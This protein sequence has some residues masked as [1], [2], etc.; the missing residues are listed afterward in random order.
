[1]SKVK[2]YTLIIMMLLLTILLLTNS[3][4]AEEISINSITSGINTG[5]QVKIDIKDLE[6]NK[7]LYC[8]QH[9]KNLKVLSKTTYTITNYFE[10]NGN[11]L[12]D[13]HGNCFNSN[14]INGEIAYILSQGDG[15]GVL[16][17]TKYNSAGVAI[18]F[19]PVYS[20]GQKALYKKFN[21]WVHNI[22]ADTANAYAYS[23]NNETDDPDN[24]ILSDA[25]NY[26]SSIASIQ[27]VSNSDSTNKEN[28]T[29]ELYNDIYGTP[30]Y[31]V[32]PFNWT[33]SGT[34]KEMKVYDQNQNEIS[35][36][37]IASYSGNEGNWGVGAVQSGKDFYII[38]KANTGITKISKMWAKQESSKQIK[39]AKI[40]LLLTSDQQNLLAV[41]T[42]TQDSTNSD[43][44]TYEYDKP[45]RG[46]F[47]LTKVDKNDHEIKLAGVQFKIKNEETGF[48]IK[49]SEST[50]SY[51]A[52]EDATTFETNENGQFTINNLL[53]GTYTAYEISNP[54]YGYEVSE[55]GFTKYVYSNCTDTLTVE[56]ELKYVKIGGYAWKDNPNQ[57]NETQGA[58]DNLYYKYGEKY[59]L[60]NN[61]LVSTD[62]IIQGIIVNL[63]DSKGNIVKTA[64][65][66]STGKYEF[67]DVLI[68][69]LSDYYV[70]FVY[71][72]FSYTPVDSNKELRKLSN[73]SKVL[74]VCEQRTALNNKFATVTGTPNLD[75]TKGQ[76]NGANGKE[77]DLSYNRQKM[78]ENNENSKYLARYNNEIWTYKY[79]GDL[80][81]TNKNNDTYNVSANTL[82]TSYSL[83]DLFNNAMSNKNMDILKNINLGLKEREQSNAIIYNND[84]ET[85]KLTING[86]TNVYK[87]G[88]KALTERPENG[89]NVATN[90]ST[91]KRYIYTSDIK[92]NETHK[93]D[94]RLRV[95]VTYKVTLKNA[96]N[97]LHMDINEL[98]DYYDAKYKT[99][100]ILVG[101]EFDSSAEN[102]G[103]KNPEK[104]VAR[105]T[106]ITN[107]NKYAT[108]E[109][110]GTYI[111]K[112]DRS[113]IVRLA[114]NESKDIFMQYE[115][116]DNEVL[117]ILNG[118]RT[119]NNVAEIYSYTTY[120]KTT[121]GKYNLYAA[122]DNDSAAGNTKPGEKATYEN[123]TNVAP[124]LALKSEGE[125]SLGG[126][127]FEDKTSG[128][129][130]IGQIREGD[131]EY[132]DG[133][134]GIAGV[135]VIMKE[136]KDD[137]LKHVI[138]TG[139]NGDY[140][141][142]GFVPGDYT[143]TYEWGN[144]KYTVQDYK[145]TIYK[146]DGQVNNKEWY[147]KENPR[148]SDA[149]DN[150]EIRKNIDAEIT[151][152]KNSTEMLLDKMEST[153]PTL[154]IGI[155]YNSTQTASQGN[156]YE[157]RINNI[158]FGISE[159]AR[160][161]VTLE[162][163]V[164]YVKL[165][166]PNGQILVEGDPRTENLK[167]VSY[168]SPTKDSKG[169]VQITLDNELIHGSV[170]Q[171]KYEFTLTNNSEL[172][173]I[174][175]KYY[176]YG[177]SYYS[178]LDI[179]KDKKVKV[180]SS[181]IVDYVDNELELSKDINKV[182]LVT[183][184]NLTDNKYI[185]S[186]EQ[187]KGEINKHTTIGMLKE[188]FDNLTLEPGQ[189]TVAKDII[190]MTKLLSN[191]EELSY[192]NSGEVMQIK[193][194]GG[195]TL[196]VNL[197]ERI[198]LGT[199]KIGG[200]IGADSETV[201]VMPPYGQQRIYYIIGT[202]SLII[203][204]TGII[205]IKKKVL[206]K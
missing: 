98:V 102:Y 126:K 77:V 135:T 109:Y 61:T 158:D 90:I 142:K 120:E 122:I 14:K 148:Y 163:H 121:D 59:T 36:F 75:I 32:G 28:I 110:K 85:V 44:F 111:S 29:Y 87:Y 51:V 72:G 33:Y 143:I 201:I 39:T 198:S 65:T 180:T 50:I 149:I 37:I 11:N 6:A 187:L 112:E 145:G 167:Y 108:G 31:R 141:I 43:E 68:E 92:Y 89:L 96:S 140:V 70:E 168:L 193:K 107:Q 154:G 161:S 40:W 81:I 23:G 166:L 169:T 57:K 104:L 127:V 182:D 103:I 24:S 128:D 83:K 113:A 91:Y 146:D 129:L 134:P 174:D 64:V 19:D 131:G 73:S 151:T 105:D 147:K 156:K 183:V 55:T 125:R 164:S 84:I 82:T 52:E 124:T 2:K 118:E 178:N 20:N 139:E 133:E 58:T 177:K 181:S 191:D 9:G 63:K 206:D 5:N 116:S 21:S 170:L 67:T 173:F 175:E 114:P 69:N 100:N 10:I 162:K 22:N 7:F 88:Q 195:S 172:D 78:E 26:A 35:D 13:Q 45:L 190:S 16:N 119:V 171:I 203:L 200:G 165:T 152:I 153:T 53:Q 80:I 176:I 160:Q 30:Y 25:E 138:T 132:K 192:D 48:F 62:Q 197:G 79:D 93:D 150:Y 117:E 188:R 49:Q 94:N 4:F 205:V 8:I 136:K 71:D 196:R 97:T 204:T 144:E 194:T 157:Y 101:T 41:D 60:N 186:N 99:D 47:E 34:L 199:Y 18:K 1:M 155:E 54:N 106:S 86:Y 17:P 95:Y 184:Q 42:G 76:A 3:V 115:L 38:I 66:D 15:Y 130:A 189:K 12:Y 185:P 27:D 137:T 123:D 46:S 74:E 202:I 179:I 159:R 56:N